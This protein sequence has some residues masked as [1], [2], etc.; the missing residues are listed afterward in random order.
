[1]IRRALGLSGLTLG[2]ILEAGDGREA[3]AVL[4]AHWVD[5]VL[6]DIHMPEMNGIELVERMAKDLC[7]I[8]AIH[9]HA[10][11]DLRGRQ[12]WKGTWLRDD[13]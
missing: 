12:N 7:K 1:M 3:L 2:D 10:C 9:T 11:G 6:T 4:D 8:V 13:L 5:I